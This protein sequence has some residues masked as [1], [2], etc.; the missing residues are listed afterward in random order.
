MNDTAP[1]NPLPPVVWAL[2]LPMIAM[3]AVV[4]LGASGLVGGPEAV[5]WRLQALERFVFAPDVMRAMLEQGEYP[6]NHMIRLVTYPFVHASM[7][8]ALFVIVI[9]LALGK[10]L[11]EAFRWWAVLVIFFGATLAGA[12]VY[13]ALPMVHTPLYGGYPPVYGLIGGFTWLLWTR[14]IVTGDSRLRAFGMIAFLIGTQLLFTVFGGIGW[15]I[16]A[17]LAGFAAGFLLC[18]MVSPGGIARLKS[19]IRQR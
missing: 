3:E 8:H 2:A 14:A 6:L 18:F 16:V 5:G 4:T 19:R 9:L 7:T 15:E 17:D 12:A 10:M 1:M 13:T 11:G